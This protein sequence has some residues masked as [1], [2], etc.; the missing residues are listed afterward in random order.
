MVSSFHQE[1]LNPSMQKV[2]QHSCLARGTEK[3]GL[4]WC[5]ALILFPPWRSEAGQPRK[6]C[7]GMRTNSLLPPLDLVH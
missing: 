2:S 6:D 4:P 5:P 3:P 7:Y 1:A